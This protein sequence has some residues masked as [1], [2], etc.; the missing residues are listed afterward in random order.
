[1]I[2]NILLIVAI[3]F[4]F[5]NSPL[6]ALDYPDTCEIIS[7]DQIKPYSKVEVPVRVLTQQTYLGV[8]ID[9]T[10][11]PGS[12][13]FLVCDSIQWTDWFWKSP[14]PMY[15]SGDGTIE[16]IKDTVDVEKNFTMH[17]LTIMA[18]WLLG[19]F[20]P[21]D[22]ILATIHLGMGQIDMVEPD[23]DDIW[24]VGDAKLIKWI[25]RS[26]WAAKDSIKI[27]TMDYSY[28]GGMET[29]VRFVDSEFKDVVG[30][31]KQGYL[32]KAT[33]NSDSV[34]IEY[35]FDA[36]KTW[37]LITSSTPNDSEYLWSPIPNTPSDSCLIL[38]TSKAENPISTLSDSFFTIKAETSGVREERKP[39][40]LP[41]KFVLHQNYPNP[42]NPS[43]KIEFSLSERARVRLEIYDITGRRVKKLLDQALSSGHWS[44]VWDGEDDKGTK[45]AS[46][47]YFYRLIASQFTQTRKMVI[48]K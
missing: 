39:E 41:E 14:T 29:S 45:V 27:D 7:V 20:P 24:Y 23:T 5:I 3:I 32:I 17:K 18:T 19:G 46:G 38:I 37:N 13:S 33:E 42:F 11:G 8:Q 1:M 28:K 10:F 31:F 15:Y 34:K 9:L 44:I 36:G 43:T 48:I 35:S 40:N 21:K 16:Y 26:P 4:L 12:D 22:S 47:V 30:G 6:L 2:R 25:S